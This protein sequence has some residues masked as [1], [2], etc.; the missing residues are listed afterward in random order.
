MA[1]A[2]AFLGCTGAEPEHTASRVTG[3]LFTGDHAGTAETALSKLVHATVW[4]ES[5]SALSAALSTLGPGLLALGVCSSC[6]IAFLY[7]ASLSTRLAG[8]EYNARASQAFSKHLASVLGSQGALRSDLACER[9]CPG[10]VPIRKAVY[11][12]PPH[13]VVKTRQRAPSVCLGSQSLCLG[14]AFTDRPRRMGWSMLHLIK[15]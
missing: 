14:E 1:S 13:L 10:L 3:G 15:G 7:C 5:P 11:S 8:V 4:L 12:A 6:F 9:H 2:A